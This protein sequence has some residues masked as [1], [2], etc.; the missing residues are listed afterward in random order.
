MVRRSEELVILAGLHDKAGSYFGEK[1]RATKT[2]FSGRK[3]IEHA[4][5]SVKMIPKDHP[6]RPFHLSNLAAN[7][8]SMYHFESQ[9]SIQETSTTLDRVR[10]AARKAVFKNQASIFEN[11]NLATLDK[12]LIASREVVEATTDDNPELA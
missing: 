9:P 2:P 11:K 8:V 3:A 4:E 10:T 1:F 5:Q 12:A 6:H 7:L